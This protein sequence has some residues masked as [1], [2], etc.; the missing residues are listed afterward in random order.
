[1][2]DLSDIQS[3]QSIKIIGSGSTGSESTPVNATNNGDLTVIDFLNNS[4]TQ[5]AITV[6]ITAIEARVGGSNLSNRK[7]ICIQ[8][9][10]TGVFFGVTNTVTI[11]SG[12]EIFKDQTLFIP[13]GP[14]TTIWLIASGAGKNVRIAE[15]A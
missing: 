10:D 14:N 1:M 9:K 12:T 15:F 8:A 4:G 5:A 11:S 7:Y 3:A 2:S 13:A 6:G